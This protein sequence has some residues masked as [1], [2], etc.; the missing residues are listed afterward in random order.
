ME[1]QL[2]KKEKKKYQYV[3][4]TAHSIVY[5]S[6]QSLGHYQCLFLKEGDE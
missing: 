6:T 3:R 1:R 2:Q 5:Q 4:I